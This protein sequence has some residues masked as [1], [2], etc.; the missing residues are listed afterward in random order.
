MVPHFQRGHVQV[1]ACATLYQCCAL[2]AKMN[3]H[4]MGTHADVITGAQFDSSLASV[5]EGVER[6]ASAAQQR[7]CAT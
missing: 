5:D 2:N 1:S 6:G 7:W 3:H 4:I